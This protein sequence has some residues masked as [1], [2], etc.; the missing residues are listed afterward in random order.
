MPLCM[1][2]NLAAWH[3]VRLLQPRKAELIGASAPPRL[4]CLPASARL[5]CSDRSGPLSL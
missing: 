2:C 4:G 3:G 5:P 1:R